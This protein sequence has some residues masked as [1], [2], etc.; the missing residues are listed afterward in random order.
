[1]FGNQNVTPPKY[2]YILINDNEYYYGKFIY[3]V[4]TIIV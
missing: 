3:N 1:M 2:I 4:S